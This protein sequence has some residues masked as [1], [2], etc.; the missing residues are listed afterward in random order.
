MRLA[1]LNG[2]K[3]SWKLA[4]IDSG[5]VADVPCVNRSCAPRA[6]RI[7]RTALDAIT[8][9]LSKELG[10]RK[11][12][13]NALNPGLIETEGTASGGFLEGEFSKLILSATPLGRLGRP[14]DIGRVAVFLASDD[15]AWVSGQQITVA[16]GHTM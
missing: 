13:V 8:T 2:R 14:E 4:D 16:G 10:G 7:G 1:G 5:Q 11:I 6:L 15:S 12:R 9:A 3:R